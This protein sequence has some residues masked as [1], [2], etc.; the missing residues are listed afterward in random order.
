MSPEFVQAVANI[1]LKYTGGV[2][3][4]FINETGEN[5]LSACAEELITYITVEG[6]KP[7]ATDDDIEG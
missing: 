7:A 6:P 1:I 5:T 2:V 3:N 4:G